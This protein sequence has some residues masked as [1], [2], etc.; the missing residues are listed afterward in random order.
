L[1][2][3]VI[4][5]RLSATSLNILLFLMLIVPGCKAQNSSASGAA[6]DA[7]TAHRVRTEIRS[8]YNVAPQIE[9]TLSEPK[10]GTMPGYDDLVV[11]FRG[12]SKSTNF[13]F[14]ISK[15]RK[16][17][18]RME[19]VDIS[20]DLM[21]KID[22][23][24]RPIRGG[25]KAK[26]MIVNYDDFQCPYCS[27]MHAELFPGLV[28]S[29]GDKIKVVYKDYP[30]IEIHPWAMHAAID[31]N[32]LADQ[33]SSAYWDFADYVHAN[34]TAIGGKSQQ[35]AFTNLDT[36]ASTQA[37]KYHLDLGKA[38]A[39]FKKQDDAG[40]RRS[41]A[42]ADKLGVDSTP[43]LFVNGER[44]SGVIPDEQLHAIVDRALAEAGQPATSAP[45]AAAKQPGDTKN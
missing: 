30:L 23:K 6:L 35:E 31:A 10:A 5:A 32:C 44:I 15:D 22:V 41:M 2:K 29:Y 14:F 27:R 33:N 7:E 45:G 40:V 25:D 18:A 34:R 8:R 38:E 17:L 16:T 26:V 3:A 12:G 11:T 43:T 28:Q 9:I 42:E 1:K 4:L 24:D 20:Q 37:N 19:K 13:D 39:C 21:S 36:A